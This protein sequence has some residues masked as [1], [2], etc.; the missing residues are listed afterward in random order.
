[1]IN[2][3]TLV[4]PTLEHKKAAMQFR[5]EW[6]DIE[7]GQRIHGSWGFQNTK[8]ENYEVWLNDIENL[9]NG[10][11][12]N[13]DFRNIPATTYFAVYNDKI[14]GTIQLRHTLNDYLSKH[15]G[16]IGYGVRPSERRKGYAAKMLALAL[17]ECKKLGIKKVLVTCDK[18]N[19]GSA[20]TIQKNGGVLENETT[21]ENGGIYQRYWIDV[22]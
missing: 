20:R 4:I 19:I 17:D 1:M 14:V 6:L 7:P 3:L 10:Q 18:N 15:G 16:H 5:Q 8:Y 11:S 2:E 9:R 22:V 13:T 12:N 21:D